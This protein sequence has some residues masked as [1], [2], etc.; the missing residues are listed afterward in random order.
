MSADVADK[1]RALFARACD[2]GTTEEEARTSAVLLLRLAKKHGLD[3]FVESKDNRNGLLAPE[4]VIGLIKHERDTGER[5]LQLLMQ[6]HAAEIRY[7]R[8]RGSEAAREAF[9]RG[10][11]S[12]V[13]SASDNVQYARVGMTLL[14]PVR[15]YGSG[16]WDEV[17]RWLAS[18]TAG[19]QVEIR[20]SDIA[21]PAD[22]GASRSVGMP[23]GQVRDWRFL[24]TRTGGGLHVHEY[25]RSWV[26]HLGSLDARRFRV[27]ASR[28]EWV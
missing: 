26:A 21:H 7:E 27:M 2:T 19:S 4:E 23:R 18:A 11:M 16:T 25:R 5:R 28:G 14:P 1:I 20:R 10:R 22:E 3:L 9:E 6:N 24:R 15:L 17:G 13:Q 12:S 8:Q